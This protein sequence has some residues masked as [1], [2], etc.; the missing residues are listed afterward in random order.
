MINFES[1]KKSLGVGSRES[2][3]LTEIIKK[4]KKFA[5][6]DEVSRKEAADFS[7][8]AGRGKDGKVFL[9][10]FDTD[11]TK[12]HIGANM[13]VSSMLEAHKDDKD[14]KALEADFDI[15]KSGI[16]TSKGRSK[17]NQAISKQISD[18]LEKSK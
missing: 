16:K 13:L 9:F 17:F 14:N 10:V 4:A 11:G 8:I 15:L 12:H 7:G 1:L 18:R 6:V 5:I 3:I 2:G